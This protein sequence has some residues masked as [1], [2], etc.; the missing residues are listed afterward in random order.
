MQTRS[1][2]FN[3]RFIVLI[4]P[5]MRL[6][7]HYEKY[8]V[9]VVSKLIN[10]RLHL[11]QVENRLGASSFSRLSGHNNVVSRLSTHFSIP[12]LLAADE[13]NGLFWKTSLK[14]PETNEWLTPQDLSMTQHFVKLFKQNSSLVRLALVSYSDLK[15]KIWKVNLFFGTSCIC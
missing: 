9:L 5:P 11:M 15:K 1:Y 6:A 7:S 3:R 10:I 13:F 2:L 14:N 8:N 4:L 12:V